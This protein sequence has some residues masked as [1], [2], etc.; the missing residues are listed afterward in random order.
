MA[1]QLSNQP[2]LGI[3]TVEAAVRAPLLCGR[4]IHLKSTYFL[5]LL[6]C[7]DASHELEGAMAHIVS[8]NIALEGHVS[9]SGY[10]SDG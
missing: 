1:S 8:T 10:Q 9:E 3:Q 7:L 6:Q 4:A 2:V 5:H